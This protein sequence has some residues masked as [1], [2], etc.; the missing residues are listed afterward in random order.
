[1]IYGNYP[2]LLALLSK[3][4]QTTIRINILRKIPMGFFVS[5]PD[6]SSQY[7]LVTKSFMRKNYRICAASWIGKWVK[8]RILFNLK[9]SRKIKNSMKC[10]IFV[11]ASLSNKKKITKKSRKYR[12]KICT[13]SLM[14]C[15]TLLQF[16]A[17][18]KESCSVF[19]ILF[20][21][22]YSLLGNQH[23]ANL[24]PELLF[25]QQFRWKQFLWVEILYGV[26]CNIFVEMLLVLL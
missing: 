20:F 13:L 14:K 23:F 22:K 24:L 3:H 26:W 7:I 17:L 11:L 18:F 6:S 1:M 25:L 12:G 19:A 9:I 2:A 8:Y 16:L 10:K 21:R 5:K 4:I 15:S